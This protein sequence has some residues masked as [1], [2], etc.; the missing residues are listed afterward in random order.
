MKPL[1]PEGRL[2]YAFWLAFLV[3]LAICVLAGCPATRIAGIRRLAEADL[4][5]CKRGVVFAHEARHCYQATQAYC[6]DA[7]I[8]RTCGEGQGWQP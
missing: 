8:E 5:T 2:A 7:G 3:G 1:T 6:R 4:R